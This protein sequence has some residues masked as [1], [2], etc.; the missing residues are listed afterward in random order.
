MCTKTKR[1]RRLPSNMPHPLSTY[2]STRTR[3]Y[4]GLKVFSIIITIISVVSGGD[5]L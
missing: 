4:R 3:L 5:N 2:I 1:I